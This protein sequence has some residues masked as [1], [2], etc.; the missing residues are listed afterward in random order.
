MRLAT[1][2]WSEVET[3][4]KKN[5]ALLLPI[6][7]TEQHGPTGLLGTDHLT[8]DAVA[9]EVG[10]KLGVMVAP[11]ICYGMAEHHM[12]FPG[13]V[14]LRPSVYQAMLREI[15]AS[16]YKHGFRRFFV[17]NGHGGNENS[18]RAVFQE[19]KG[20]GLTGASFALY[21]WWKMPEVSKLAHELYGDKEGFHATPS[22]VSLTFHLEGLS[23]RAYEYRGGM[24]KGAPWPLT[25][26]EMRSLFPDGV[27]GADPGLA[28]PEHGARFLS[29]AVENI[30]T[31]MAQAGHLE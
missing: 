16:Y 11:P 29:V 19:L 20:E 8:A 5:N 14:T 31:A 27:M 22:E 2:T 10:L 25:A 9:R 6:G 7:S 4:L 12:A 26:A 1:A 13:S 3:Y 24:P 23:A 28:R 18:V 15:F 21:N 17:V 30:A